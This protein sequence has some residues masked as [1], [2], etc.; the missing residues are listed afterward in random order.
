[1]EK[2]KIVEATIEEQTEKIQEEVLDLGVEYPEEE[3]VEEK[4]G[5]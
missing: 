3:I 4:E 1:M 2:E 5:K